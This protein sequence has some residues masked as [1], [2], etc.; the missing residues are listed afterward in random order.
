ML[1]LLSVQ[2][3]YPMRFIDSIDYKHRGIGIYI[4]LVE[5]ATSFAEF[6]DLS[7]IFF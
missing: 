1:I 5:E 6:A 3:A 4:L 7:P 2:I